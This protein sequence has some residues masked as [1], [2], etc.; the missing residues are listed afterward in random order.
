MQ[1]TKEQL[2]PT[3]V[4]LIIAAD[5]ELLAA[6]KERVLRELARDAK[7]QGFRPG[8]A[9]LPVV[10]KHADPQ[11]LQSRFLDEALN[12]LYAKAL[13][14]E[15][16]RPVAQPKASVNKFVPFSTLE[17]EIEVEVVGEITL[18]DYK[19]I[20]LAQPPV[21]VDAK[22]VEAVMADLRQRAAER[23]DVDR[24]AK[25]GD[26]VYIDFAGTDA[27]TKEPISGADGKNYPLV[28]GS[29][30][31]IPGFEDN[32][33]GLKAGDDKSFPLTFPKD[34]G[35]ASLQNRKVNFQI[36]V[37]KVQELKQPKLDD[38]FAATVGPFK[39]VAELEADVKKQLRAEREAQAKRDY[40]SELLGMI[41][42]K[43][44]VAIPT[45]LIDEEIDRTEAD[46]RQNL[47]YR[48]QTWE[49]HLKEEGVT[50]EEH[51][52]RQREPAE[53]RVKAGLVLS[54]IAEKEQ[55][56]V[57]PEELDMQLRLLKG[58]YTDP[59]MQAQLDK[60]E[61]KRELTSRLMTQKT[62]DKLAGYA[63]AK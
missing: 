46:E 45:A 4:K 40:E 39:T 1:I 43:A 22:D 2:S 13:D 47:M 6:A 37:I 32:L 25:S 52:E 59:K 14:E 55:V 10:E 29:N 33:I 41:A 17:V 44:K 9:P 62:M 3:S 16:L 63:S 60:P 27:K 51:R 58:Q 11:L 34:Y 49:E 61:T 28:L 26:Q 36:S 23:K 7:L 24:A 31:F 12:A 35:V 8:K 54:E 53:A 21:T 50:A 19:K 5:A 42:E 56:N 57:T 20:K 38:A 18:P 48:G 15:R 30:S